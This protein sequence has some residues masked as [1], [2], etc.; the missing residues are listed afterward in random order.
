MKHLQSKC[1]QN[2]FAYVK[3]VLRL[4]YFTKR[5]VDFFE[6]KRLKKLELCS[7]LKTSASVVLN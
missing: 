7:P 6:I 3:L 4:P 2:Q 1:N 5:C